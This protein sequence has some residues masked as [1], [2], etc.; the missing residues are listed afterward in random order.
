MQGPY[1]VS[2]SHTI[3]IIRSTTGPGQNTPKIIPS[4]FLLS[5]HKAFRYGKVQSPLPGAFPVFKDIL[6]ANRNAI[7][8]NI[9]VGIRTVCKEV[10]KVGSLLGIRNNSSRRVDDELLNGLTA[11]SSVKCALP[12]LAL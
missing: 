4:T 5:I 7:G 3:L 6:K 12:Q 1:S 8:N 10:N 2:K 9:D 11:H